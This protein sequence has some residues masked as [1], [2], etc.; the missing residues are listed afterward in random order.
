MGRPRYEGGV[1]LPRTLLLAVL[2]AT[3]L[4]SAA[5][6]EPAEPRRAKVHDVLKN[7]QTAHLAFNEM[8]KDNENKHSM[9]KAFARDR[10]FRAFYGAELGSDVPHQERNPSQHPELFRSKQ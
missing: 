5:R 3:G 7:R 6:A 1:P 8:T 10:E 2:L 4:A 9:A